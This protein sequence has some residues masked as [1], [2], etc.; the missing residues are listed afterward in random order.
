MNSSHIAIAD[1]QLGSYVVL[2]V[3]DGTLTQPTREWQSTLM[4]GRS[5]SAKPTVYFRLEIFLFVETNVK[6]KN[7][8]LCSQSD[9]VSQIKVTQKN[10]SSC[11]TL[12][13]LII[14]TIIIS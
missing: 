10:T 7:T 5:R 9:S 13:A 11:H 12:A 3:P 4:I 2:V 8:T 14:Y 1:E 6:Y